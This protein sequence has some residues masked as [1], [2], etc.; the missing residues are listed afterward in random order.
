MLTPAEH[1]SLNAGFDALQ[2]NGRMAYYAKKHT[3]FFNGIHN[4]LEFLPWHRRYIWEM[5]DDLRAASG[6][7]SLT[8]PYIDEATKADQFGTDFS[9]IFAQLQL[10]STN[11]CVTGGL[12]TSWQSSYP[13]DHCIQRAMAATGS[14]S[15]RAAMDA[16]IA[17]TTDYSQFSR[18]LEDTFHGDFH[19]YMGGD[20]ANQWSSNDPI[21]FLHHAN[22]DFMYLRWQQVHNLFTSTPPGFPSIVL[23]TYTTTSADAH[24]MNGLCVQ[25]ITGDQPPSEVSPPVFSPV[26]TGVP[27]TPGTS[28]TDTTVVP[29]TPTDANGVPIPSTSD[30]VVPPGTVVPPAADSPSLAQPG[31]PAVP[32]ASPSSEAPVTPGSPPN[33]PGTPNSPVVIPGGPPNAPGRPVTPGTPS[34]PNV[35]APAQPARP[36]PNPG[37]GLTFVAG[38]ADGVVRKY[39]KK[40]SSTEEYYKALSKNVIAFAKSPT[41]NGLDRCLHT[42]IEFYERSNIFLPINKPLNEG[43]LKKL[44]MNVERVKKSRSRLDSISESLAKVG[45]LKRFDV[46]AGKSVSVDKSQFG[47]DTGVQSQ[48]SVSSASI[49]TSYLIIALI[50]IQ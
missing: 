29:G 4:N 39:V 50:C 45:D 38:I 11:G 23:Q 24:S 27:V 5:E 2:R 43:A 21:F 16:F 33:T 3:D 15:G 6:D 36:G 19:I 25:Y 12:M 35:P 47:Q 13:N 14:I 49:L 44:G 7:T 26:D 8:L 9:G 46:T 37:H 17:T 1:T 10:G 22:M 30:G 48:N 31:L 20:M 40:G 32:P 42:I 28:P 34:K 18:N 41:K